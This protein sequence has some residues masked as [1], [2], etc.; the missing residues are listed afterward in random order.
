MPCDGCGNSEKNCPEWAKGHK[1]SRREPYRAYEFFDNCEFFSRPYRRN[2]MPW[3]S[4]AADYNTNS[5][6]YYDYLS[7]YNHLLKVSI[8]YINRLLNRMVEAKD[9]NCVDM[10]IEGDWIDNGDCYPDNYDDILKISA[11]II[12]STERRKK[13]LEHLKKS[14]DLENSLECTTQGL[15]APDYKD[16]LDFFDEEIAKLKKALDDL[17]KMLDQLKDLINN[18]KEEMNNKLS[19][20][21]NKI[22]SVDPSGIQNALQKIIDNLFAAGHITTNNIDN[23]EF[24]PNRK[25][26][27]GTINFFGGTTDGESFIRTNPGKTE[28]DITAGM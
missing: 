15:Y 3:Y 28:N 19:E 6:S 9:T 25:I 7:Q 18:L 4:D 2:Y 11:R 1:G 23:F 21:E 27:A 17:K 26:A 13:R 16:I 20:L 12:L 14:F 22:S 5:L 8:D 10:T 24:K